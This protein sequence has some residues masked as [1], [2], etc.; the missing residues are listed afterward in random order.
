MYFVNS[1]C[2]ECCLWHKNHETEFLYSC[3][4]LRRVNE[5]KVS[6]KVASE[7]ITDVDQYLSLLTERV[8][9]EF[10]KMWPKHA[11]VLH[12]NK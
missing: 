3:F 11:Q 1:L 2:V 8:N 7:P 12:S 9:L 10:N 4:A 5:I 6:H